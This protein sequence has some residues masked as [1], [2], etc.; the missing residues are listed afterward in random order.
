MTGAQDSPC[1]VIV[2]ISKF[3]IKSLNSIHYDQTNRLTRF[4]RV[5]LYENVMVIQLTL[6]FYQI[7]FSFQ[8]YIQSFDIFFTSLFLREFFYG[9]YDRNISGRCFSAFTDTIPFVRA[10]MMTAVRRS[11]DRFSSTRCG[12]YFTKKKHIKSVCNVHSSPLS[13]HHCP[14]NTWV[15]STNLAL[16]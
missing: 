13:P 10:G 7:H 8:W 2:K 15:H 4:F 12:W 14:H 5:E 9:S 1:P 6:K 11:D 16:P 3:W